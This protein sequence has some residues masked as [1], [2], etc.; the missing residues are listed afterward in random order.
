MTE[1]EV[2]EALTEIGLNGR[3]SRTGHWEWRRVFA[4]APDG[5][6]QGRFSLRNGTLEGVKWYCPTD[7]RIMPDERWAWA[8]LLWT[9]QRRRLQAGEWNVAVARAIKLAHL[10]RDQKQAIRDAAPLPPKLKAD[11]SVVY[12]RRKPL[13]LN[14]RKHLAHLLTSSD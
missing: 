2:V 7:G 6:T 14:V 1:S 10:E 5:C 13:Q 11:G 4:I 12:R 9:Q 3:P 8:W